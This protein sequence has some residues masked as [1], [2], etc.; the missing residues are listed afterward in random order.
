MEDLCSCRFPHLHCPAQIIGHRHLKGVRMRLAA[1]T[2][3]CTHSPLLYLS[4]SVQDMR[5][6]QLFCPAAYCEK[7]DST[8]F[9]L[10]FRWHGEGDSC[11]RNKYTLW[12]QFPTLQEENAFSTGTSAFVVQGMSKSSVILASAITP[13]VFGEN[14][15]KLPGGWL[16]F[17]AQ[18]MT[19]FSVL[20]K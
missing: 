20:S 9:Q 18:I 4:T 5:H 16:T 17:C 1:E 15:R 11:C 6:L 2:I 7:E 13:G 12:R 10:I 3:S 8:Q 14:P 19:Q